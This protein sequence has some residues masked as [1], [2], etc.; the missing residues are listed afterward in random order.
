M[1]SRTQKEAIV[2]AIDCGQSMSQKS[3]KSDRT[4]FEMSKTCIINIIKQKIFAETRNEYLLIE[5]GC[6]GNENNIKIN[7]SLCSP[8]FDLLSYVSQINS[9]HIQSN[10]I[11]ALKVSTNELLESVVGQ[12]FSALKLA[13]FTNFGHFN[14]R[15]LKEFNSLIKNSFKENQ[16]QPIIICDFTPDSCLDNLS[17]NELLAIEAMKLIEDEEI[18]SYYELEKANEDF[19]YFEVK[20]ILSSAWYATIQLGTNHNSI[21]IPIAGYIKIQKYKRKTGTESYLKPNSSSAIISGDNNNA[22]EQ[23]VETNLSSAEIPI[24]KV[25]TYRP[26]ESQLNEEIDKEEVMSAYCYGSTLVPF[27]D[28]DK[29]LFK[30]ENTK[31]GFKIIGLSATHN[32]SSAHQ[33]GDKTMIIIPDSRLK[34]NSHKLIFQAMI[35]AM[36]AKKEVAIVRYAYRDTTSPQIGYLSPYIEDNN[37]MLIYIQLPFDEDVRKYRFPPLQSKPQYCPT[38]SQ[39]EAIDDLMDAMDLMNADIDEDGN[40]CEALQSDNIY[41]P[42]L[43]YWFESLYHRQLYKNTNDL[44]PPSDRLKN[45]IEPPIK[46]RE[47]AKKFLEKVSQKF[48]LDYIKD[49]K[50]KKRIELNKETQETGVSAAKRQ[51]TNDVNTDECVLIENIKSEFN[52]LIKSEV[53]FTQVGDRLENSIKDFCVNASKLEDFGEHIVELLEM[54]RK[55]SILKNDPKSFNEFM[56]NFMKPFRGTTLWYIMLSHEI[57]LIG[58]SE[59]DVSGVSQEEVENFTNLIEDL[60]K[61]ETD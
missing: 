41:D 53:P 22:S 46:I 18:G 60:V 33:I 9:T 57:G 47:N 54:Y 44:P 3:R 20:K 37:L 52:E 23:K 43:Q 13:I 30:Y 10:L 6:N 32:I 12:K 8:N 25:V 7:G 36:I 29:K 58:H 38:D 28:D 50:Y 26:N 35:R 1:G 42:F 16:I 27:T 17:K 48:C 15:D 2:I 31:K 45:S 19:S 51:K 4:V 59:C 21:E 40:P 14:A 56:I 24:E 61:I 49:K 39:L 11:N 34:E 5:F 55:Q